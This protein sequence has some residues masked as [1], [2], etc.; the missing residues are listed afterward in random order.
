[1]SSLTISMIV[2]VDCQPCS[3]IVGLKTRTRAC[4]RSRLRAKFQCD[5]RRAVE[6]RG[7]PLLQV[8]GIDLAEVAC[9]ERLHGG[10]LL[11]RDPR[12]D[13][14]RNFVQAQRLLI[15]RGVVHRALLAGTRGP[16]DG[17]LDR[18]PPIL[19]SQ[20]DDRT[21]GGVGIRCVVRHE[22]HRQR[23]LA[24]RDR[25][26]SG[27]SR[28]RSCA[29]S[30]LNGSSSSSARGAASSVR[31]SATRARWPP[32][33]VAGSRV[34]EAREIGFGE[35]LR[36]PRAPRVARSRIDARQRE[37]QVVA[38]RQVR[39]QQVVLEQDADAAALRRQRE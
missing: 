16:S 5:K 15:V 23:A 8:L 12:C 7:L 24:R 3:S 18:K 21:A 1:M 2:C 4:P 36:R 20:H 9:D 17:P 33:S 19:R 32:E 11:G 13:E 29:S 27:G 34:G 22:Q 31:I 25:T 14:L 30:L 38:D 37:R 26:R 28:A 35:R 6:V 39:K 10:A